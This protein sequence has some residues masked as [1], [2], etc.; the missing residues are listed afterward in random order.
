M[1]RGRIVS[2]QAGRSQ[3]GPAR[4]LTGS[5]RDVSG[6]LGSA[7]SWTVQVPRESRHSRSPG[8]TRM[9][10]LAWRDDISHSFVA[11]A[12]QDR[13]IILGYPKTKVRK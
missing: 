9:G 5:F 13:G 8:S 10:I 12:P 2:Y 11:T 6:F 1:T 3:P 7:G 4:S